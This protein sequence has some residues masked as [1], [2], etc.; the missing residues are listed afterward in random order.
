[1]R[2]Y[3]SASKTKNKLLNDPCVDW[4]TKYYEEYGIQSEPLT[5]AEK[6]E[7]KKLLKDASHLE[8]LFEGGKIFEEYVYDFLRTTYP[9]TKIRTVF[10]S[11]DYDKFDKERDIDGHIRTKYL[12]T[13]KHMNDGIP[14]IFQG[15]VID[16][17]NKVF[18]ISDILIRSDYLKKLFKVFFSD[19]QISHDAPFLKAGKRYHYRII[20]CK[21][22]TMCLCVDGKTIR[23][24]RFFPAY[25]GQLA[26]YTACL[27]QMQGYIPEC[28]YILSKAWKIGTQNI[29]KGKEHLYRGYSAFDRLGI[30][31]YKYRDNKYV[32]ATK[33]AIKWMQRVITEG[34]DWKYGEKPS[35]T[36]MYP[37][38]SKTFNPH[39]D[40]VKSK[41]ADK[42][43]EI[44]QGWFVTDKNRNNAHRKGV[45]D[46][47]DP[48]CT[49]KTLNIVQGARSRVIE[50][51]LQVNYRNSTEIVYP[52]II[53]N[54]WWGWQKMH[55][56]DYY[57]D[58]ETI[59]YALYTEPKDM[60]ICDS[61]FD[62]DLT[63]MIGI[64]FS[65]TPDIDTRAILE[66][67]EIDKT[68]CKYS[69]NV[70][71]NNWEFVCLYLSNFEIENETELFR[72]FFQYIVV[73]E[74]I[75]RIKYELSEESV[76]S[77][78]FHWT[79]AE[80]RFM[81]RAMDR[82]LSGKYVESMVSSNSN[83]N[84]QSVQNPEFLTLVP[85]VETSD[86]ENQSSTDPIWKFQQEINDLVSRFQE[87]ITWIDLH[88][89][90]QNEPIIVQGSYCFKLKHVAN[91][92]HRNGLI[93]TK[94]NDDQM[95]NGFIAMIEAIKIYRNNKN[96]DVGFC[97]LTSS[98][99]PHKIYEFSLILFW[100]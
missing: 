7:N 56:L 23:N 18:G 54:N 19:D 22:T 48:K 41:I 15:V 81:K 36:E 90:F 52:K 74:E 9:K 68:K 67:L 25:K 17:H 60:N 96:I 30:I 94:W 59:N 14:L 62:S 97:S 57:V 69:Y 71:S 87:S 31:D 64:G 29:P 37:N 4:L 72:M 53:D 92:F 100:F 85:E 99:S 76:Y 79:P 63:F 93:D 55:L 66:A 8:L 26:I 50:K 3:V 45:F 16:D 91:A 20:D 6:E 49:L 32:R 65:N 28:A 75:I 42:Y 78:I 10:T 40:S 11:D 46:I 44:T 80:L 98:D 88:R 95:S 43:G 89:I 58:F 84:N 73:R 83:S 61:Y 51:F 2:G 27:G 47:R 77:R 13:I 12:E 38:M 21:W 86:A 35:V 1:M 34:R 39:Y 33:E 5:E 82:L 70:D 24:E